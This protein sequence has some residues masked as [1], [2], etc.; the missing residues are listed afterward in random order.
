MPQITHKKVALPNMEPWEDFLDFS[1]WR[2][3][4]KTVIPKRL[5]ENSVLFSGNYL[6]IWLVQTI[7]YSVFMNWRILGSFFIVA[8]GWRAVEMI[9]SNACLVESRDGRLGS[10]KRR[11]NDASLPPSSKVEQ[12]SVFGVGNRFANLTIFSLLVFGLLLPITGIRASW[13]S[14]CLV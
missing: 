6:W 9:Y 13:R 2:A 8:V 3:P 5:L 10:S 14:F 12:E 7:I 4:V 1:R 11:E